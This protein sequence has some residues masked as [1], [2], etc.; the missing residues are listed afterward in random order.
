MRL[1]RTNTSGNSGH[2]VQGKDR[3]GTN[4][5]RLRPEEQVRDMEKVY[6]NIVVDDLTISE[7]VVVSAESLIISL[8]M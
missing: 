4:T 8:S 2:E 3:K 5:K 7:K 1:H 6:F